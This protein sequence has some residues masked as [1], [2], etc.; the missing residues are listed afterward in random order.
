MLDLCSIRKVQSALKR[1]EDTL[2]TETG[3]SFNDALCLCSIKRGIHEPGL[4]A[5]EMDLSPSR[6]TRIL[7][8]LEERKY[9]TRKISE[10][11]RRVI[12]VQLTRQGD[13][14][15]TTYKCSEIEIP[16]ILAFTQAETKTL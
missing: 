3:I 4:I 1:F 8:V 14:I 7:N 6:L 16:E 10:G 12:S 13:K 5:L 9:I 15:V 11:D 2:K